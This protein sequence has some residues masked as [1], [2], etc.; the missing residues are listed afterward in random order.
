MAILSYQS[1]LGYLSVVIS[2]QDYFSGNNK[3]PFVPSLYPCLT[4][5]DPT[6]GISTRA[7]AQADIETLPYTA[8]EAI[9]TFNFHQQ[10]YIKYESTIAAL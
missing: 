10:E 8:A 9:Q 6:Q 7:T 5:T 4:Q 3:N 2:E 1:K